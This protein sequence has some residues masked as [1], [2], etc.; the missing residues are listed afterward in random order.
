MTRRDDHVVFRAQ[1]EAML[2][3][4]Q[5]GPAKKTAKPATASTAPTQSQ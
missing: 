5:F 1:A 2:K 4:F 3:T